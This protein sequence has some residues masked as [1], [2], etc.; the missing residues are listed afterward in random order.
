MLCLTSTP[1]RHLTTSR[2]DAKMATNARKTS[3]PSS[4]G[5][6]RP[7]RPRADCRDTQ[8]SSAGTSAISPRR[9][10]HQLACGA[11]RPKS[12]SMGPSTASED[13]STST[14][15]SSAHG[16]RDRFAC[17]SL[18]V[19]LCLYLSIY[20]HKHI[21]TYI[22][23]LRCAYIHAP[24]PL[25]VRYVATH[26]GAPFADHAA[27][28]FPEAQMATSLGLQVMYILNNIY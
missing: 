11:L 12:E 28:P 24:T 17:L 18:H 8:N 6:Y 27:F 5:S 22:A 21:H 10:T 16:L 20:I 3:P 2:L 23:A 1:T 14:L 26:L 15:S 13:L 4:A 9:R 19:Y 7:T 25:C